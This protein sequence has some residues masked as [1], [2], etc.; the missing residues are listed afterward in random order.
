MW[1]EK[2]L[3]SGVSPVEQ[4]HFVAEESASEFGVPFLHFPYLLFFPQSAATCSG[5]QQVPLPPFQQ[6]RHAA[7][8]AHFC[9]LPGR[10]DCRPC[11]WVDSNVALQTTAIF[12]SN[13][14]T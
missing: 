10:A 12:L 5:E 11:L 8:A 14:E 2:V 9:C 1:Q 4:D 13:T 6:M 3:F 7:S